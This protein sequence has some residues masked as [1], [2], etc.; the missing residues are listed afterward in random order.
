MGDLPKWV[1]DTLGQMPVVVGM[2]VASYGTWLASER[3]RT[4]ELERL[5]LGHAQQVR[6]V[7]Q[8]WRARLRAKADRVRELERR[9][10]R[11]REGGR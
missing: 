4:R 9:L 1:A 6:L 11:R 10:R 8:K 7:E 3:F 5:E 2:I